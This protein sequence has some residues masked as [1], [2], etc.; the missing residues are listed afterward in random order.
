MVVEKIVNKIDESVETAGDGTVFAYVRV[1]TSRKNADGEY[2]QNFDSQISEIRKRYLALADK[3]IFQ[4]RIS[5]AKFDRPALNKLMETVQSGDRIVVFK[6]DRLGRSIVSVINIVN[7]LVKS[8]VTVEIIS[9]NLVLSGDKRNPMGRLTMGL[10][11]VFAEFEREII[12]ERV[13]AGLS[14]AKQRGVKLGRT[15][16]CEHDRDVIVD[17]ANYGR[18]VPEICAKTRLSRSSVYKVL[19]EENVKEITRKKRG[20]IVHSLLS[21]DKYDSQIDNFSLDGGTIT[22]KD[23]EILFNE[24]SKRK[25]K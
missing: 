1:S 12:R 10:L 6:L 3:N 8:D 9:E 21:E 18:S 2:E 16:I 24:I 17:M 19:K 5:G 13:V 22:R 23:R 25:C 7:D 20:V 4:D 15:T 14:S 11:S